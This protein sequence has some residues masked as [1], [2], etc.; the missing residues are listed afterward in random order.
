MKNPVNGSRNSN[1]FSCTPHKRLKN[2]Y[3][4]NNVFVSSKQTCLKC[5]QKEKKQKKFYLS[6]ANEQTS[7]SD[8]RPTF[9][10]RTDDPAIESS[11]S[12]TNILHW[13]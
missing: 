5:R 2:S 4:A 1:L 3:L 6:E 13:G 12:T 8:H 11:T 9:D 10:L 7:F